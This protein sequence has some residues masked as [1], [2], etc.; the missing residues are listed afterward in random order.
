MQNAR[1]RAKEWKKIKENRPAPRKMQRAREMSKIKINPTENA[2]G[3]GN[4]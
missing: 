3:R 2:K 1:G 4:K